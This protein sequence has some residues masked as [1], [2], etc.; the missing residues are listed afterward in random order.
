MFVPIG[1][2]LHLVPDNTHPILKCKFNTEIICTK[3][4]QVCKLCTSVILVMEPTSNGAFFAWSYEIISKLWNNLPG[5]FT[6]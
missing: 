1:Y 2:L 5:K 4:Q 6:L 3:E